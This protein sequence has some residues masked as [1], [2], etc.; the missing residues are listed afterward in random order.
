MTQLGG[1]FL[2]ILLCVDKS[3]G[4]LFNN[5]RQSQDAELRKK[6]FSLVGDNKLFL[7][8]YSAKQFEKSEQLI[9]CDDFLFKA[10]ADD[11]CFVENVNIPI[12]KVNEI[13]LFQWNR[14]YPAD[15]YF[16]FN[17]KEL[18]FKKIFSENFAGFSHKKITLEVFKRG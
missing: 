3:N 14:D 5:R 9:V 1:E 8:E 15:M 13:Y 18:G 11:F 10:S 12:E 4:M 17:L 16:N 6:V 7:N 2:K